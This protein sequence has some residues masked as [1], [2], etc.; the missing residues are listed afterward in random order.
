MMEGTKAMLNGFRTVLLLLSLVVLAPG[1]WA[2]D[3]ADAAKNR[4]T[5]MLDWFVNPDHAVLIVAQ[6][7]GFFAAQNLEV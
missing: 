2:Q 4:L 5:V 7:K 6:E 3:K 1:G